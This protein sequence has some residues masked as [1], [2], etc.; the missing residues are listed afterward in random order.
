MPPQIRIGAQLLFDGA[1]RPVAGQHARLRRQHGQP[2]QRRG[3]VPAASAEEVCPAIG[4]CE[5]RI[6]AEESVAGTFEENIVGQAACAEASGGEPCVVER[7][8]EASARMSSS[9]RTI[10]ATKPRRTSNANHVTLKLSNASG[11]KITR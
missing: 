10:A 11:F 9:S 3:H 8:L 5:E 4:A 7:S 6:A 1:G 2:L